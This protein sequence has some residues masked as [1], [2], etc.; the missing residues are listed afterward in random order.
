MS[1]MGFPVNVEREK[2]NFL[3]ISLHFRKHF[4]FVTS[5]IPLKIVDTKF[6][7]T[8]NLFYFIQIFLLFS[9]VWKRSSGD[10]G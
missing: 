10:D 5:F 3:K 2:K 4:L 9:I 1:F 7:N 6:L 8:E